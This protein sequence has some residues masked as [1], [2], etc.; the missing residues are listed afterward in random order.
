VSKVGRSEGLVWSRG[1]DGFF[2]IEATRLR[3][4]DFL[5]LNFR[6]LE[7]RNTVGVGG[8]ED[9]GDGLEGVVGSQVRSVVKKP[10]PR[11]WGVG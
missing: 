10:T 7:L 9:G 11:G 1:R 6:Q 4:W 3:W 2:S 8:L 5:I